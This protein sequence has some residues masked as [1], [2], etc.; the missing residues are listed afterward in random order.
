MSIDR[1]KFLATLHGL[2]A[3]GQLGL[4][5]AEPH[6]PLAWLILRM[7]RSS[8]HAMSPGA[9]AFI[10]N[11]NL[12]LDDRISPDYSNHERQ[13]ELSISTTLQ[14]LKHSTLVTSTINELKFIQAEEA[15]D[16]SL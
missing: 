12:A 16:D 4:T 8:A 14:H 13:L 7:Q 9:V 2:P 15:C 11:Q 10:C 3:C 5:S 1:L 6:V